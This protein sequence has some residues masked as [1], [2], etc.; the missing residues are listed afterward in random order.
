MSKNASGADNQQGSPL[1]AI[2]NRRLVVSDD[3]SE[4]TR[5]A[6]FSRGEVV[7]YFQGALHDATLNKR[8]R[9]RFA[10]KSRA[11]LEYLS[12]LLQYLGYNSWIY[13]EGQE[14]NVYVLETLAQF[15][16]FHYDP[17]ALQS[18]REQIG[19]VRGFF[20]AE[21]GIPHQNHQRFYVQFVQK[22]WMKL[23]KI[24][25]ILSALEI[26]S[27]TIHNPSKNVDPDYWRF[28]ISTRSHRKFVETIGSWYP[29]KKA[30]FRERMVI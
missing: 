25:K 13:K 29:T 7:P 16:D 12:V 27:G 18:T 9:Y 1:L 26:Q 4:T 19:Y 10:Q 24:R 6:P 20:D 2:T 14:R 15:L 21:G 17:S 11:W 3:P 30:I 23:A 28:Y 5:R 8:K 22:D